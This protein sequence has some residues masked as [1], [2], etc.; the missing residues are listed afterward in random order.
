[1]HGNRVAKSPSHAQPSQSQRT[2]QSPPTAFRSSQP[3]FPASTG[4][5]KQ[6]SEAEKNASGGENLSSANE[7]TVP[8]GS[9]VEWYYSAQSEQHS[10]SGDKGPSSPTVHT[11]QEGSFHPTSLGMRLPSQPASKALVQWKVFSCHCRMHRVM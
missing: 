7:R 6:N 11:V 3:G 10:Q 4:G 9:R 2:P 5:S 1:M 8:E